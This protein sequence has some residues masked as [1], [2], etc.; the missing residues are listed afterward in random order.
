[1]LTSAFREVARPD[2]THENSVT[3]SEGMHHDKI[4]STGGCIAASLEDTNMLDVYRPDTSWKWEVLLSRRAEPGPRQRTADAAGVQGPH[5]D[6]APLCTMSRHII[7]CHQH[8]PV[9]GCEQE[10]RTGALLVCETKRPSTNVSRKRGIWQRKRH[11][12]RRHIPYT[13][14]DSDAPNHAY[15]DEDEQ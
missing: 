8:S 2:R 12:L 7:A 9:A 10:R 3:V 1:M 5:H 13:Y 14:C 15:D 11:I 6:P 4:S